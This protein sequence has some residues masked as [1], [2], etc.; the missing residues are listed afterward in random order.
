MCVCVCVCLPVCV[1]VCVEEGAKPENIEKVA[2]QVLSIS[3]PVNRT[4]LDAVVQNIRDNI[5]N[6]TDVEKVFNSTAQQLQQAQD[7]LSRAKDAR[8]EGGREGGREGREGERE[9]E[10]RK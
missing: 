10:N 8:Y 6:L 9:R 3:L 2:L 7:L 1:C 5:A 4:S